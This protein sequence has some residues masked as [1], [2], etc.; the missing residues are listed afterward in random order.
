LAAASPVLAGLPKTDIVDVIVG[1][2]LQASGGINPARQIA[3]GSGLPSS[4]PA[5]II[6]RPCGIG[7]QAVLIAA[8]VRVQQ[9]SLVFMLLK[10]AAVAS[11]S[12]PPHLRIPAVAAMPWRQP[13]QSMALGADAYPG[14]S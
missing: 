2:V 11:K 7:L 3:L 12:R 8:V 4:A 1:D 13:S 10:R 5:Q 9:G 6:Q 14:P